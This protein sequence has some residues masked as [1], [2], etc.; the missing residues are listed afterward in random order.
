MKFRASPNL[1][2]LLWPS[3]FPVLALLTACGQPE[4]PALPPLPKGALEAVAVEPGVPREPLARAVD[5]LFT[6]PGLGETRAL[7]VMHDGEI[8]AERYAEGFDAETPF[9]GWSM[10]KTVTGVLIGIL[11]AEGRLE[12]DDSPPIA[13]WQR[14]GDPRGEITLRQLLQMR[15]GLRHEEK[16]E[17]A[18]ESGEVRMMF[19]DGRDNMA[20]WAEAQP[21]E[22]EPGSTFEYSTP[23]S[24]ILAD[25]V[26]RLLAPDGSAQ[27]RQRV[28]AE[29]LEARLA[30][31]LEMESLRAEY[32]PAGTMLG[33]SSIWADARD[34]AR[35]GEFLRRGG[36]VEGAQVVPRGWID[37]MRAENP[38]APDY[39]AQL[40]LNRPSGTEREML[41]PEQGPESL[42][43][44]IGHLGQYVLV[45]PRQ[46]LT[47]VRLG[48]TDQEDREALVD[49]LAEIVALY[50][51]R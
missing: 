15:S 7:V 22:H 18:Y 19:L 46:G 42:H 14:P 47:V 23:T 26:A 40:W 10:S 45:S 31:P 50:P 49:A 30:V 33:G 34:W 36:S 16:A 44:A 29:F 5:A 8:V 3:L 38:R 25:I 20:A 48:K 6:R 4:A 37:F 12:L 9:P 51:E 13:H 32:D 28:V 2:R 35:F 43:A 27:E 1:R 17:P 24:L 21:L 39:G 41:F 11:V